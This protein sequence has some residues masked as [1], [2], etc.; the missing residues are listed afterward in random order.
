LQDRSPIRIEEEPPRLVQL[1]EERVYRLSPSF[2]RRNITQI[3]VRFKT[4]QGTAPPLNDPAELEGLRDRIEQL[5]KD[6]PMHTGYDFELW[7]EEPGA[8]GS[9]RLRRYVVRLPLPGA[10]GTGLTTLPTGYVY[11]MLLRNRFYI[12]WDALGESALHYYGP[13][14]GD[15]AKVLGRTV[16]P[17]EAPQ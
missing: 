4:V 9:Y 11:S 2:V 6:A 7:E 12:Q 8:P 13:F 16:V 1:G 5:I 3:K 17:A 14:E 15:P 10:V